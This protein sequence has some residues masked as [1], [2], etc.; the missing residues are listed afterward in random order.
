ME[1]TCEILCFRA[2]TVLPSRTRAIN[3][4]N[5][6]VVL[7]HHAASHSELIITIR[8]PDREIHEAR[9]KSRFVYL[10]EENAASLAA[11]APIGILIF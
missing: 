9:T 3:E 5:Y 4:S 8:S 10:L 1:P 7:E 2:R 6:F 11:P